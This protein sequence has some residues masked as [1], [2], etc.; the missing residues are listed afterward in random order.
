MADTNLDGLLVSGVPT[1]GMGDF[2]T[3]TVFFVDSVTGSN[4]NDGV[5]GRSKDKPFASIDYAVGICTA[6][7]G[8]VI[9][10]LPGHVETITAANGLDLDV[11]TIKVKGLGWGGKKP[12]LNFTT[13]VGASCRIN[14]NN[15]WLENF[16][17]T[18]GIDNVTAALTV[19]GKTD[20]TL[21]NIECL[22][23][24]G[25]VAKWFHASDGSDRLTINGLR[26]VGAAAAGSTHALT[27]DG[28]DDLVVKN[29]QIIGNFSTAAIGFITTLSARVNIH[30]GRIWNQNAADVSIVD[31]ITGSTGQIGP[32]LYLTLT[33]NA[34]NITEAITGATFHVHAE[35]GV[36]VVNA[37][38]EA[39]MQINWTDSTDA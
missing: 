28:C 25:Q 7:K 10:A 18:G 6:D 39:G 3:G 4:T 5:Y 9:F 35:T 22:D 12:Q 34:A 1:Q 38:N 30:D 8:D 33:D 17:L 2:I 20:V 26:V 37:V 24:T 13:A 27:F 23:V 21:R 29:F 11:A 16:R 19:N 31:T 32:N 15:V 14:A 36:S